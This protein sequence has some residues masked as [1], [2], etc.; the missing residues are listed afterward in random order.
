MPAVWDVISRT[1]SARRPM[2]PRNWSPYLD[3]LRGMQPCGKIRN[4]HRRRAVIR[5]AVALTQELAEASL[6]T[7]ES[8]THGHPFTFRE[9]GAGGGFYVGVCHHRFRGA[10]DLWP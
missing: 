3:S 4:V 1:A 8:P 5:L 9:V 10:G 7:A 6:M 2:P